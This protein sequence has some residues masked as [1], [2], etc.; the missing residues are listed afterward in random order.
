MDHRAIEIFPHKP[1]EPSNDMRAG[2]GE[3]APLLDQPKWANTWLIEKFVRWLDGGPPMETNVEDNL[4]SV[5]L[6]FAAIQSSRTGQPVRVQDM[7]A[8]RNLS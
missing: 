3:V 4:Q 7:L 2:Q 8:D 1:G 6:I 5:A